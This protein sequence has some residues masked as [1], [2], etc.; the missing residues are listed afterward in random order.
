MIDLK[1]H[2]A[3]IT[4]ATQGVGQAIAIAFAK[5]GANLVLHGL[6]Q[7]E[8]AEETVRACQNCGVDVSLVTGD[9]AGDTQSCVEHV[10]QSAISAND[11]ISILVNNAGTY[12]DKP[13]LE[14]DHETFEKTMRLNVYSYYFLTQKFSQKWVAESTNGRVLMVGSI[15]AKLAEDVHTA[16][17]TSKGAVESMVKT[18]CVSLAPKNIRVNGIAPGLFYT[19]LT[20]PALDNADFKQWMELHTPNQ[21]VPT[22]DVCGEGAVYLVSDAAQHVHGHMLMVDGGMSIWQ[23][24]DPPSN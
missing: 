23:Q 10:F 16:Y 9:L 22:P 11:Q 19:P 13:F 24:P 14:M 1:G 18:L 7:D 4:G 6:H 8:S 20:A 21:T 17:D 12:I 5:A 15:N 3:L 2:S